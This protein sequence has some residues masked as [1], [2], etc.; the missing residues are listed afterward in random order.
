MKVIECQLKDIP[1]ICDI[2]KEFVEESEFGFTFDDGIASIEF[3]NYISWD[4]SCVMAVE[5]DGNIL[6]G[7]ILIAKQDFTVEKQG[8]IHKFYIR[9]P[10]RKTRA[11]FLLMEE[12]CKWF[13]SQGCY[14]SFVTSTSGISEAVICSFSKLMQ[15]YGFKECGPTLVRGNG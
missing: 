9:K 10:F 7:A 1:K 13:D 6:G 4:N 12:V 3:Y 5:K 8:F 11:M 14:K 15:K 2:V